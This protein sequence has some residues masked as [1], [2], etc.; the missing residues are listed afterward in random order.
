MDHDAADLSP[1]TLAVTAGRPRPAPGAPLS[2]P[3]W[4]TSTYVADGA[5]DYARGGNPTWD[6]FEIAL[7]ALE[8]GRARV[9]A[10]GVA[11]SAAAIDLAPPGAAVVV[12]RGAYYGTGA[13][14]RHARDGGR[15]VL[16]EVDVADTSA[17]LAALEGAGM[18]W[19]ETPT[20]PLLEV[21][22]LPALTAAARARGVL[23]VV[24]NTFATPLVQRPLD[25]GADVVVHSVTKYLSGHSDLLL[26]AAVTRDD[27]AGRALDGAIAGYRRLY[28]A[29]AGPQEAWLALRGLRT[30]AL[31]V[32]RSQASA[33]V[34]A[35][36]LVEHSAVEHSAVERVRHPS[37][38]SDPGHLRAAAQMRGF[39]SIVSVQVHG[40]A[41]AADRVVAATRLWVHATSLGGVESTLER[42]RRHAGEPATV[43]ENLLRLSVGIEDVEDLWRDLAQALAAGANS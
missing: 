32:E 28:G 17:V 24:D 13:L 12:P 2:E 18:L 30:L 10:S 37:L 11:A 6:A 35:A 33:A 4:L 9:F 3:I 34:L 16:R 5:Y 20:N 29:V 40:G 27:P 25:L 26:G 22:D 19:I 23:C 43:P 41:P 38:P 15:L 42:R 8:G 14:L 31:R 39:G 7:G 1:A 21:A 36:R